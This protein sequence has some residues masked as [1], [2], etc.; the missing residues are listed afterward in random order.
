M[1][2]KTGTVWALAATLALSL[3][4]PIARADDQGNKNMWRNIGIGSAVVAG[5]GLLT[6]NRT[7]AIIGVA[8][9]AYSAHRYEEARH[10]QSVNRQQYYYRHHHHH[11]HNNQ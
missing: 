1:N 3:I 6:H 11:Y 9:A 10:N 4:A 7:E 2:T 5:H 8:G